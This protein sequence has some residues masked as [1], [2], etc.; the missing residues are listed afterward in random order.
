M[1]RKMLYD[2]MQRDLG[3]LYSIL[4][5]CNLSATLT[6]L[7]KAKKMSKNKNSLEK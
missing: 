3:A 6:D 2:G 4:C 1:S 5:L 7:I